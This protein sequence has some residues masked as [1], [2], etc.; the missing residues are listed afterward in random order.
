MEVGGWVE[1]GFYGTSSEKRS[2]DCNSVKLL[3]S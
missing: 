1:E 3:D 2:S